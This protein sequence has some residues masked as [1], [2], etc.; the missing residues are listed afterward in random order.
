[1]PAIS[2]VIAVNTLAHTIVD[3]LL[4]ENWFSDR[5]QDVKAVTGIGQ[6]SLGLGK[7]TE[8]GW[9]PK[10]GPTGT[11]F[12]SKDQKPRRRVPPP[13]DTGEKVWELD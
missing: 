11:E 10:Y 1:L 6:D 4:D 8:R 3:A 7:N 12:I 13:S 2:V 5:W 9:K